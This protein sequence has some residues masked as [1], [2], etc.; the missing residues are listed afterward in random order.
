M[1]PIQPRPLLTAIFELTVLTTGA[2][3]APVTLT[4]A[5]LTGAQNSECLTAAPCQ[6]AATAALTCSAALA[7][8]YPLPYTYPGHPSPP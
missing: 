7:L 3:P 1:S 5:L 8:G 4:R 2:R 6:I